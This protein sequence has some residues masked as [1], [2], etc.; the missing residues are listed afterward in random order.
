MEA[1]H[2]FDAELR[3]TDD[4]TAV[5]PPDAREGAYLA[6]RAG[7]SQPVDELCRTHPGGEI[8]TTDGAVIRW[9]AA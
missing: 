4:T 3:Y 5:V 2:L 8:R 1:F 9:P 7:F 6:V